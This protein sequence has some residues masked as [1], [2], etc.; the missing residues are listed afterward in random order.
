MKQY[1]KRYELKNTAKDSLRGKYGV[2]ILVC[3]THFFITSTALM[4]KT[5]LAE[6]LT[7]TLQSMDSGSTTPILFYY[8]F[9]GVMELI[10]SSLLGVLQLG[11]ALFFL[12]IA[13]GQ[14]Y[15]LGNLFYGYQNGFQKAL[16]IAT[17]G[18]LLDV[19]CHMPGQFVIDLYRTTGNISFLYGG[20]IAGIVGLCI[21]IPVNLA[22]S[23]CY[24]LMLDFPDQ[25]PKEILQLSI[26][27]M[28]GH[29]GRLFLIELS[30]LPLAGLC[31]LTFYV[32]FLW[33]LPYMQMTYALFFLD[34]MN[35][36]EAA[37]S[38]R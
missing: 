33:L 38:Y 4:L 28:R 2:A 34:L 22:I 32:C 29:K 13:C 25:S 6:P 19:L 18:A 36:K 11:M 20:I 15:A 12:N 7:R 3:L 26:R 24:F 17:V 27:T 5:S 30:F 23:L 37:D 31:I 9:S 16:T 8:L 10:F 35:P 1:S 14:P 21:Y